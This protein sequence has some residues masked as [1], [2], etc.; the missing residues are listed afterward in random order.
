MVRLRKAGLPEFDVSS[1]R[2]TLR[3]RIEDEIDTIMRA[4]HFQRV[5]QT[6]KTEWNRSTHLYER[7]L[8][9]QPAKDTPPR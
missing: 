6:T 7:R 2:L 8:P 9:Q 1:Q 5:Q 3:A 4:N